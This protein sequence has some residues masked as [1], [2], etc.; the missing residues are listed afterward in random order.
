MA[1]DVNIFLYPPEDAEGAEEQE[2][3][4]NECDEVAPSSLGGG[5]N[6]NVGLP[7]TCQ[8]T[9]V[10]NHSGREGDQQRFKK[11]GQRQPDDG[12]PYCAAVAEVEV[13][14][15]GAAVLLLHAVICLQ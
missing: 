1:G 2:H 7:E 6:G 13:M 5:T 11:P 14:V 9:Q 15:A 12:G 4:G 10:H 3:F 8:G